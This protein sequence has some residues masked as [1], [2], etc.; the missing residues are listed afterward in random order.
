MFLGVRISWS[1]L[2][3]GM[4]LSQRGASGSRSVSLIELGHIVVGLDALGLY[5]LQRDQEHQECK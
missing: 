1:K 4:V 3:S 2:L 5:M